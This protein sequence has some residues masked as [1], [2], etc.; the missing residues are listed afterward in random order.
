M[1]HAL[2]TSRHTHWLRPSVL[3][4]A[5]MAASGSLLTGC[6]SAAAQ[7]DVEKKEEVVLL[8][9]AASTVKQGDIADF[10]HNTAILEA[11]AEAQVVS[12]LAGIVDQILV[13]EGD[14]VRSG[15]VL[16]RIEQQ[17]Y[18]LSYDKAVAEWQQA[19][20]ELQ[21]LE[22][23]YGQKLISVDQF[24][25]QKSQVASLKAVME[26]AKLDLTYTEITAPINGVIAE[27]YVKS[28][29]MTSQMQTRSMFHIVDIATLHA[30]LHLPESEL[31]KVKLNQPVVLNLQNGRQQVQGTVERIAPI[32]DASTGTFK[33]TVAV[34]NPDL[35]LKP[36]M[37]A[38]V[39]IQYDLHQN[40]L[41]IPRKA[42]ISL[43]NHHQVYRVKDGTAERVNVQ[44]GYQN[45]EWVEVLSG[46]AAADT[47]VTTGQQNLKPDAKVNII[48]SL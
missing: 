14:I 35:Q 15:Q 10:Y 4:L 8:P 21:R 25:K 22:K 46:I 12:H 11:P 24:E 33:V 27:R 48:A 42:L 18:Q 19:Q 5:L 20:N 28:G 43:D 23:V 1:G 31:G 39:K 44:I 9:V 6:D 2:P 30:I 38:E 45:D 40:A 16:A 36:G 47:V 17:R 29:N 41:L 32:V 13:E 37:F 26:L 34:K 3:A 7:A